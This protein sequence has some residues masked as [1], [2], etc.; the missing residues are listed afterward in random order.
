MPSISIRKLWVRYGSLRDSAISPPLLRLARPRRAGDGDALGAM[1]DLDDDELVRET[2]G[3]PDLRHDLARLA[4]FGRVRLGVALDAERLPRRV[5][6]EGPPPV[7]LVEVV[8]ELPLDVVPHLRAV[9]LEDEVREGAVDPARRG[10]EQ[11]AHAHLGPRRLRT[12]RPRA[13]DADAA[14]GERP[15]AVDAE[16]IQ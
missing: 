15:Q 7:Q 12:Q 6:P 4:P 10:D 14:A 11:P 9:R 16:G 2:R 13:P 3:Q 8:A 5:A 1:D